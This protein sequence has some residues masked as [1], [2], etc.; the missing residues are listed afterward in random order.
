MKKRIITALILAGLILANCTSCGNK[1]TWDTNRTYDYAIVA[2]PDGE[3]KTIKIK[4]WCDYEGEQL[5]IIADD[6]T[7]YLVSSINCVL[8]NEK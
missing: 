5:Q 6:G 2:F 1:D 3:T 4:K 7:V 8:V